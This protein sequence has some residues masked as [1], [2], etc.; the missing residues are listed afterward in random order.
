M[1]YVTITGV[2]SY[3]ALT[4]ELLCQQ[5]QGGGYRVEHTVRASGKAQC[6]DTFEY[7]LYRAGLLLLSL[8]GQLWLLGSAQAIE[9]TC[10]GRGGATAALPPSPLRQI[11]QHYTPPLRALYPRFSVNAVVE[12]F[13]LL[14][15]LDKTHARLQ[16]VT[17][18]G[19]LS[20]IRPQGLRG[21]EAAESFLQQRLQQLPGGVT[22]SSYPAALAAL[23]WVIEPYQSKPPLEF[24]PECGSK[25]MVNHLATA[26]LSIARC[27]EEGVIADIDTE[28][29]HDYRVSL[30]KIRSALSLLKGVY[31]EAATAMVK[32]EL[33]EVMRHTN[34]LRD[35]DVYLLEQSEYEQQVAAPLRAGLKPMFDEFAKQRQ[36]QQRKIARY[37]TSK[38]Y[39]KLMAKLERQFATEQALDA[40]EMADL[41][42]HDYTAELIWKRYK[43]VAKV[44]AA[45]HADTPDEEVHELRIQCKKLRYLMEFAL[46]FYDPKAVNQLIKALK[47]LQDVLGKFNDYSVQQLS[48]ANYLKQ[49]EA[50]GGQPRLL[51]ETAQAIGA[52]TAVL[53]QK[54]CQQRQQVES[55]FNHF[56]SPEV[57]QQFKELFKEP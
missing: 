26:L 52:L 46:P 36:Q 2:L 27:N 22:V 18:N 37:F 11:V 48:L 7:H 25:A 13:A 12:R 14:D 17:L 21:Y 54:Q 15:R 41:P 20:L 45:I 32:Q 49:L 19:Q 31:S 56:N 47:G 43:K 34:Q 53:Y 24:S 10:E 30:R 9:L 35:L 42:A 33:A 50:K 23:G 44:A 38:I 55:S 28:F 4:P 16:V 57:Q 3:E 5:L 39:L 6:L 40:G 1:N 51:I 29:L 8:E